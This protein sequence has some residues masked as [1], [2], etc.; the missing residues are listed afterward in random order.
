MNKLT[1]AYIK[2]D[3]KRLDPTLKPSDTVYKTALILL[4]AL[5]VGANAKRVAGFAKLPLDLVKEKEKQIRK[6]KIWL[7]SK[8]QCEWFDEENGGVAFWADVLAVEGLLKRVIKT[9]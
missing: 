5:V 4:S 6:N 1:L 9:K 8:T 2:R 3:I 7:G